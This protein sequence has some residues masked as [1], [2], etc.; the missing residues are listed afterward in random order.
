MSPR[1]DRICTYFDGFRE[2]DH[3]KILALLTDDVVRDIY[4]SF[5][6]DLDSHVESYVVLI[7]T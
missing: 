6:V 7:R 5:D 3:E 4:F 1:K 2:G